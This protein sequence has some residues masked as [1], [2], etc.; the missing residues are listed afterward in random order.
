MIRQ[1]LKY[2]LLALLLALIIWVYADAGQNRNT[3]R[4]LPDVTVQL[5]NLEPGHLAM[6]QPDS[7]KIMLK[8]TRSN[9]D[10][11][12]NESDL[13]TAYVDLEGRTAGQYNLPVRISLP[14][15]LGSLVSKTAAPGK[16]LVLLEDKTSRLFRI[17]VEMLSKTPE[18]YQ[19]SVP[20][21][22]SDK[23]VVSGPSRLVS[24]V[25]RLVVPLDP[26]DSGSSIEGDFAVMALSTRGRSVQ[27][28]GIDPGK[29]HLSMK[30]LEAPATRT[31]YIVPDITGQPP[32]PCRVAG[33]EVDPQTIVISGKSGIV[34]GI[35]TIKTR[36]V[37]LSRRTKTFAEST[38]VMIP[39]GVKTDG[40]ALVKVTVR[41]EA[42]N[43]SQGKGA[44]QP[45]TGTGL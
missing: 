12:S 10:A 44:S 6:C 19:F 45:D 20:V 27:G 40:P 2:K 14:N 39:G 16:V 18:G 25:R 36:P 43:T 34:S 38:E 33:I 26:G 29:V 17:D 30:L 8:G 22:S 15:G 4:Q 23:A 35:S 41:I 42:P 11:V 9:L 21:L 28:V 13:V 5:R 24:S 31:A 7:I 3:V 37:S 1:N 32:Y